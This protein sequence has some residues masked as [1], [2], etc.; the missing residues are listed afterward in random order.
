MCIVLRTEGKQKEKICKKTSRL[1]KEVINMFIYMFPII[2]LK[3]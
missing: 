1:I 2:F 3:A